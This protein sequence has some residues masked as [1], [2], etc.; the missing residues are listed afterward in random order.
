M[1]MGSEC[2][3]CTCRNQ[4]VSRVGWKA[5]WRGSL[6]HLWSFWRGVAW[7]LAW[8]VLVSLGVAALEFT[9]WAIRTQ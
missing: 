7:I 4:I 6:V 1:V 5:G 3:N 2:A 9:L 8:G